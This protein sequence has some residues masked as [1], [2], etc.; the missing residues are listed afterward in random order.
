MA[1]TR[2]PLLR[3]EPSH[4]DALSIF[5]PLAS[6]HDSGTAAAGMNEAT[7]A[8]HS[9][10]ATDDDDDDMDDD[11][12][13]DRNDSDDGSTHGPSFR[14]KR[15]Y[16]VLTPEQRELAHR[17]VLQGFC[18]ADAARVLDVNR[19][20]LGA[21][22]K[23]LEAH[24]NGAASVR[25]QGRPPV[26]TGPALAMAHAWADTKGAKGVSALK[27]Q[28]LAALGKDVS[29]TTIR[30]ALLDRVN[31]NES[32]AS[33]ASAIAPVDAQRPVL[34]LSLADAPSASTLLLLDQRSR[35]ERFPLE[36]VVTPRTTA[37]TTTQRPLPTT[38][39]SMPVATGALTSAP[40]VPAPAPATAARPKRRYRVMTP[41]ERDFARRMVLKGFCKADA[42]RVLDVNRSTL[43]AS[44]KKLA[45]SSDS[46]SNSSAA[47]RAQGRPPV[48]TGAAL[49]MAH[50]W[51]DTKGVKNVSS[52]KAQLQSAFGKDVS[53]TTIRRVLLERIKTHAPH[54]S[55]PR[56]A[57]ARS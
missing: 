32:A 26:L 20:T 49:A 25:S 46:S 9:P 39:P 10:I 54:S 33:S 47:A 4:V 19:R 35:T 3:D 14:E 52:L 23:K 8:A 40:P 48:L 27:A 28:L 18:K 41:A 38:A 16:R 24:K 44:L 15:R 55:R 21:S 57:S 29:L 1:R 5:A 50:D 43:G 7:A 34:S 56:T 51:A 42:A 6:S 36:L 13:R 31:A 11:H 53:V 30:R 37:A 12:E 45:S 17:M 2:R 22:L